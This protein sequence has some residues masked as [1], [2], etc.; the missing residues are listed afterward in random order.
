MKNII[1]VVHQ[2]VF[3]GVCIS[4]SVLT[5]RKHVCSIRLSVCAPALDVMMVWSQLHP[6][7]NSQE[8]GLNGPASTVESKCGPEQSDSG[9]YS[10]HVTLHIII[11]YSTVVDYLQR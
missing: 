3:P 5:H 11:R 9:S 7:S 8:W 2:F 6:W 4:E 1:A 10:T